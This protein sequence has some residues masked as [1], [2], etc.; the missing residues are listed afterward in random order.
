[1]RGSL[2]PELGSL[3]PKIDAFNV[4]KFPDIAPVLRDIRPQT[5]AS[6]FHERLVK[7]INDYEAT[8]DPNTDV[9]AR[10][11]TFGQ[12]V[13]IHLTDI[14]YWNPAL[15]RFDG[16]GEDGRPVQLIQHVSQISVLLTSV[17]KQGDAPRRIGF[18]KP[19]EDLAP[20]QP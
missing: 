8:L 15:I 2:D 4:P 17:P 9:G 16:I 11:V 12:A 5:S 1:M 20:D 7:W 6:D 14:G 13:T 3:I 18:T 10:L 19:Q